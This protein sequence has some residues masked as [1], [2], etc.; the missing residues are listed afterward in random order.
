MTHKGKR[1]PNVLI[2]EPNG[3]LAAQMS[4]VLESSF[5]TRVVG[6]AQGA[7]AAADDLM[8]SI[9]L[10]ELQLPD[11]SITGFLHE[12]RSYHDWRSI[13]VVVAGFTPYMAH[14]IKRVLFERFGVTHVLHKSTLGADKLREVMLA[15]VQMTV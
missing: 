12:F 14:D 7:I 10:S 4:A 15:A 1:L 3:V 5:E 9:V 11:A 6:D 8:P 13:P 2:L